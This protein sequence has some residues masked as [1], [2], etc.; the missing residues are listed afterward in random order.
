MYLFKLGLAPQ[1]QDLYG[2]VDFTGK[3]CY[4]KWVTHA[5]GNCL[6]SSTIPVLKGKAFRKYSLEED[7]GSRLPFSVVGQR[8][9][10]NRTLLLDL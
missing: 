1:I 6:E 4:S 5:V 7:K 3:E 2:K 9:P 8:E 10:G